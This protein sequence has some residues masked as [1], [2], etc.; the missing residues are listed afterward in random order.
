M[1]Y[2]HGSPA[3]SPPSRG[4]GEVFE[5][6]LQASES[7]RQSCESFLHGLGDA[8]TFCAVLGARKCGNW[9]IIDSEQALGVNL[10]IKPAM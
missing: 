1:G 4:A 3:W 7:R 5:R 6:S 9:T 2:A 8:R 10:N